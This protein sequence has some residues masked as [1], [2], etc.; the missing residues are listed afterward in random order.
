MC[1]NQPLKRDE[2]KNNVFK[3]DNFKCVICGKKAKDAHHIIERR[4]FSNGG[5]YINN[6]V[7][8]CAKH[9]IEAEMTVISCEELRKKANIEE[10]I[11]PLH[12][13]KEETYDKWGNIILPNNNRLKGELFFDI[14]VQKILKLG[15][16]LHL[17]VDYI[18][19][20]RTYHLPWSLSI[21]K[22]DRI[23]PTTKDLKGKEIVVLEKMDGE[24]TTLYNNHIHAR[25]INS[26][27]HIS[28]NWV[29]NFHSKF[30]HD[31]PKGWRICGENL[32]YKKSIYYDK[33]QSFFLGFSM[34]NNNVCLS[35]NETTEWFDL[36]DIKSVPVIY[37]GI[38]E[39]FIDK[40]TINEDICEGYVI[41]VTNSF[42]I[43]N[44]NT[45][46]GKYVR[47]DHVQT[48]GHWMRNRIV[49]NKLE[50]T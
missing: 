8:L 49:Q 14:S 7:S 45:H 50:N 47:K 15:N 5:Y 12:F 6:G 16:V 21:T 20:P 37:K 10:I 34:W 4:L 31:I 46:V 26:N 23:M 40:Q 30:A 42:S 18:K 13:Y 38:Y 11:L 3:R 35:W 22:N 19:Y 28:R 27:N 9:H 41:R 17:F 24:N 32:H 48:H 39:N 33:L 36:L 2:F 29:K 25:S 43:R 1:S 44:F